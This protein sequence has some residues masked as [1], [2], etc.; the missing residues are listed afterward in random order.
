MNLH[1]RSH[2]STLPLKIRI[3]ILSVILRI[4]Y[5]FNFKS[6]VYLLFAI[7]YFILGIQAWIIV[8]AREFLIKGWGSRLILTLF[9]LGFIIF[10]LTEVIFFL[11]FFWT[12]FNFLLLGIDVGNFPGKNLVTSDFKFLPLLNT[13]LLLR[14]GFS[15]TFS[16]LNIISANHYGYI[17][18]MV[19]TLTLGVVFV[20]LQLIEYKELRFILSDGCY[21]RIFYLT[22][23][24]HGSH[25]IFGLIFLF[26]IYIK[27]FPIAFI[28]FEL[29]SW[30]WHFV[31]II[32]L[33]LFT[34]YYWIVN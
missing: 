6:I 20:S 31:D 7:M 13:L 24:F 12:Y 5:L 21:S 19:I 18:F 3:S 4:L 28:V 30:Y 22:T 10:I 15:L 33:F 32:W 14:R 1:F 11:R 8:L 2:Y 27:S 16:H 23:S 26:I 25:V 29:A 17:N 34:F 9:K